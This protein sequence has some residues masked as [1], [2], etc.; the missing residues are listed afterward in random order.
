[1][2][3]PAGSLNWTAS[4]V[5]TGDFAFCLN[6]I[7]I[8]KRDCGLPQGR[9]CY[10]NQADP[11]HPL[12]TITDNLQCSNVLHGAWTQGGNCTVACAPPPFNNCSSAY[13]VTTNQTLAGSTVGMT[14]DGPQPSCDTTN[15]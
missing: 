4:D 5:G 14:T 1:A 7:R 9:C 2:G 6:D 8:N 3:G 13:L 10:P 11:V 15:I 12:C